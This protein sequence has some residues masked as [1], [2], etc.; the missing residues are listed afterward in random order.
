MGAIEAENVRLSGD[1]ELYALPIQHGQ[2]L[3]TC[4]IRSQIFFDPLFLVHYNGN[5]AL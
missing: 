2:T 1:R 5:T 4:L 3:F